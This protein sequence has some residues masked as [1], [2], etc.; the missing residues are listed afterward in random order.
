MFIF[1]T[2]RFSFQTLSP[3]LKKN[4]T[5]FFFAYQMQGLLILS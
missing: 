2:F 1:K 5:V 3:Q 4:H